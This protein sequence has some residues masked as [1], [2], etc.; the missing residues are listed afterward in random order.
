MSDT[1]AGQLGAPGTNSLMA[2]AD[3]VARQ[4]L[5]LIHTATPVKIIAVHG[6]GV[7]PAPTVD[8]QPLVNMVDGLGKHSTPHDTVYGL[9]T[10]RVQGGLSV[11]IND[12]KVGDIGWMTTAHRDI[13]K[14]KETAAA[15]DP[16]SFRRFSPS[17]SCYQG[18]TINKGTPT[19][20]IHHLPDGGFE[21][22]DRFGNKIVMN[23]S[24]I[25]LTDCNGNV[26]DM[27]SGSIATTTPNLT[28]TQEIQA[29]V[30]GDDSVGLQTHVHPGTAPPTPGT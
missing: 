6:G 24:G 4:A 27:T 26:I 7:G 22:V 8:A 3:F 20:Y 23:A 2:L 1:Y 18:A 13:S 21:F 14:V 29:G 10:T 12:P 19:D 17:D 5:G 25:K 15:A 9:L 30:G 16:D 11:I 28:N